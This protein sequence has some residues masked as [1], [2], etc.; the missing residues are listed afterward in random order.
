MITV[1]FPVIKRGAERFRVISS[2][3]PDFSV[4]GFGDLYSGGLNPNA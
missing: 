3:Y 1:C 2:F 4:I